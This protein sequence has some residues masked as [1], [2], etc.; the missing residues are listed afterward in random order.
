MKEA[1]IEFFLAKI[2][3]L[4]HD[5]VDKA[6]ILKR[7]EG[8]PKERKTH[9]E[10]AKELGRKILGDRLYEQVAAGKVERIIHDSDRFDASIDRWLTSAAGFR[11]REFPNKKICLINIFSG[12]CY[13]P[14]EEPR[15]ED[16]EEFARKLGEL[17][18]EAGDNLAL[19]Y[20]LLYGLLEP[21]FYEYC[22]RA[23]SPAD[24]RLPTHS[25]FDHLYATASIVNWLFRGEVDKP[26]GLLVRIDL[27]GVQRFIS[28]SRKLSDFWASSWLVSFIAWKIVEKI[29]DSVGPDVLI[30]PTARNNAFYYHLLLRKLRDAKLEGAYEEV[31]NIAKKYANY[32]EEFGMPRH[33]IIPAT[34]D[35]ILPPLDLLSILLGEN[36]NSVEGLA[37]YFLKT[38]LG[39]WENLVKKIEEAVDNDRLLAELLADGFEKLKGQGIDR[40]PP[41]PLRVIIVSVPDEVVRR[42]RDEEG[43]LSRYKIYDEAFN[44]LYEKA[45]QL[46]TLKASPFIATEITDWT[47]KEWGRRSR[48]SVCSVCGELP[49]VLEIKYEEDQYRIQVA[50]NLRVYF[51]RGEKLCG[52]CL[53]KRLINTRNIFETI[54]KDVIRCLV[55][56]KAVSFPS[57][58]D[59]ASI[60]F[61][62]KVLEAAKKAGRE[63]LKELCQ[64]IK[65]Y[66]ESLTGVVRSPVTSAYKRLTELVNEA[67]DPNVVKDE[68]ARITLTYF[69]QLQSEQLYLRYEIE[70]ETR[71][72][73]DKFG[74]IREILKKILREDVPVGI[75]YTIL[76]ADADSLGKLLSGKVDETLFPTPVNSQKPLRYADVLREILTD[77]RCIGNEKLRLLYSKIFEND[78]AGIMKL[79]ESEGLSEA[80]EHASALARLFKKIIEEGRL[81]T[82]PTY[83][84][85]LSRCLMITAIKDIEHVERMGGV[86][87]YAGGDDLLAILPP[88]TAIETIVKTRRC[89]SDG[90]IVK[91]FYKLGEGIY[92]A[93][94]LASRSYVAII[95]HYMFPMNALLTDSHETMENV[96]KKTVRLEP[97]PQL[98]KDTAVIKFITRGGG[99]KVEGVIPLRKIDEDGY[100]S[101]LELSK[102]VINKMEKGIFSRS[103]S[104]DLAREFMERESMEDEGWRRLMILSRRPDILKSILAYIVRRNIGTNLRESDE[105][106][107]VEEV[108]TRLYKSSMVVVKYP[109]DRGEVKTLGIQGVISTILAYNSAVGGRE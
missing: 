2:G 90:D 40:Q 32:D 8:A 69:L 43:S 34:I 99:A 23:V 48:Y 15:E 18:N 72:R 25:I 109:S 55:T 86:V 46:N 49:S 92:P 96:A 33:P 108:V 13:Y 104:Y 26:N 57:T 107:E 38:Y 89:F 79:L 58:G 28:S 91:G 45:L 75:Y 85:T 3:A 14:E 64:S 98:E 42:I 59:V 52:Y 95:G 11:A 80:K 7:Y 77:E 66:L 4:L 35:L 47:L 10:R 29:V 102:S 5:P 20:H 31:M 6:W 78:A 16:V 36:L 73:Q 19:K 30:M 50:E 83:H 1:V 61:K 39:V 62:Q 65:D 17:L 54:A 44:L 27:G 105:K 53:I 21:L 63:E 97:K 100:A 82:S 12:D 101:L 87:I 74:E 81:L 76:R 24:T 9:E 88:E 71:R 103:L 22:P 106:W 56:P 70:E 37:N 93:G 67:Q 94:G 68:D 51:D 60:F 84:A 41:L